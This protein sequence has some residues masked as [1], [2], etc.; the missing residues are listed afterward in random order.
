MV[1]RSAPKAILE[2]S[3]CCEPQKC[4]RHIRLG[5]IWAIL[6][7]ILGTTG[8]QGI[9]K[10]SILAPG[11]AKISKNDIQNEASEKFEICSENVSF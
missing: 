6:G 1:P 11:C 5:T 7:A 3:R 10:A 2:A 8:R 9:P 4:Q